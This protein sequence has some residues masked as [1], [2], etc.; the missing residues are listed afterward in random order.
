MNKVLKALRSDTIKVAAIQ[1]VVGLFVVLFT[2]M[3]LIGYATMIKSIGDILLR[4]KT[5][6]PLSDR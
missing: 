4:R 2:E 3:D 1:A 5:T 6:L